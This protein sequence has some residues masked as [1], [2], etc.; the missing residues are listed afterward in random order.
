MEIS[1]REKK[2][3]KK[4]KSFSFFGNEFLFSDYYLRTYF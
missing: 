1:Y 2:F 4:K 3:K